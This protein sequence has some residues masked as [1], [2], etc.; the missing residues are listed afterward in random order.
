MSSCILKETL[1]PPLPNTIQSNCI[2]NTYPYTHRDVQLS[3]L[4]RALLSL[5]IP[6]LTWKLFKI[7]L[8]NLVSKAL[9]TQAG[10]PKFD[11]QNPHKN[12]QKPDVVVHVCNPSVGRQRKEDPWGS[13]ARRPILLG[14][15]PASISKVNG[16]HGTSGI[17][18]G[19]DLKWQ[20]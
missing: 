2:L 13:L 5:Q 8:K 18:H 6:T 3:R 9:A 14:K 16:W 15:L 12:K 11:Q 20:G 7:N 19:T 1:L 10:E 4:L 17:T